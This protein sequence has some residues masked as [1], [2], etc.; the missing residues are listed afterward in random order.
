MVDV[1]FL[2]FSGLW[3]PL[4]LQSLFDSQVPVLVM[5]GAWGLLGLPF[6]M[7]FYSQLYVEHSAN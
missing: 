4:T 1:R 5:C 6:L 3:L 2:K 7:S